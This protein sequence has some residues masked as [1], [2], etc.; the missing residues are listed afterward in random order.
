MSNTN[1]TARINSRIFDFPV[2]APLIRQLN[3]KH[4]HTLGVALS[5]MYVYSVIQHQVRS[6]HSVVC[7]CLRKGI[8]FARF[9]D[10]RIARLI[11]RGKHLA[12]LW[13]I[14]L[15]SVDD[16]D[17][18]QKFAECFGIYLYIFIHMC[19]SNVSMRRSIGISCERLVG[20]INHYKIY[21][22]STLT[23]LL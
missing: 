23:I 17:S 3:A 13:C 20:D 21:T 6:S 5:T 2:F 4:T 15:Y 12:T 18:S 22:N 11:D 7:L 9:D 19:L 8:S 10:S 1:G 14:R 16:D